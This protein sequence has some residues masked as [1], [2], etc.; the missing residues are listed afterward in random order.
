MN[1]FPLVILGV[2]LFALA[3]SLLKVQGKISE[4]TKA[5]N[6]GFKTIEDGINKNLLEPNGAFGGLT[7]AVDQSF[8]TIEDGINVTV[9]GPNGAFSITNAAL[10][11]T[12]DTFY[13]ASIDIK[14]GRTLLT[15]D[16]CGT[17]GDCQTILDDVG[18]P[19]KDAGTWVYGIGD[20][21]NIDI[22]G[23]HPLEPVAKPFHD[24]GT[25]LGNVGDKCIEA[26]DKLG[27]LTV[28]VLNA[29]DALNQLS[30]QAN[31]VGTQIDSLNKYMD[32]TFK[33]GVSTSLTNLNQI[34]VSVDQVLTTFT[35][36]VEGS[37]KELENARTSLD[38][39]L[40]K[41]VN[42]QWITGLAIAGIVLIIVG[43]SIGI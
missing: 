1:G 5:V 27:E 20:T 37:V 21:I 32:T 26:E 4:I 18:K 28:R 22:L 35:K 29:A 2:A 13:Q 25:T 3:Y 6:L 30:A 40:S 34:H 16:V 10:N 19:L 43:V 42:K 36:G 38:S 12:R 33:A 31:A 39:L 23:D 7:N 41:I 8:Q 14:S 9:L 17:I 24:V 15:K 11:Y